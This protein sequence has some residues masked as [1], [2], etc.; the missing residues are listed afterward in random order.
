[1]Y[2]K[3]SGRQQITTQFMLGI[4]ALFVLIPVLWLLRMAFD[5]SLDGD[6]NSRPK[7]GGIIPVQPGLSNFT[8]AWDAPVSGISFTKLLTNSLLVAGGTAFV[9]LVFGV[10]AAYAFARFRFPGREQWLFLTLV[11]VTLPPAGLAAP[12][13]LVIGELRLRDTLWGL[14]LVYS[15]IAVPFALWTVRNAIQSVPFELEEAAMLEGAGRGRVFRAIVLP[16]ILPA[17]VVAGFIAFTLAWSEFALAWV[18]I[19]QP[20]N[21][22]LAMVLY[23][24]RGRNGVAWGNLAALA[25]L[26]ALPIV[27]S[28]YLLGRWVLSGLALG[29]IQMG[30]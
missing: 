15:A 7:D 1:M 4:A 17:I 25:V 28:F 13:F 26:V 19:S 2:K 21:Q 30:K 20:D 24:M 12:F 18:L 29:A 23:T 14:I 6:T 22:T 10:T 9:A 5:N 27:I 8:L 3:M 16:L 11:L